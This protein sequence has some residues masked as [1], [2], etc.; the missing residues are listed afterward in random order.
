MENMSLGPMSPG[1]TNPGNTS[2]GKV[3]SGDGSRVRQ[4]PPKST[5]GSHFFGCYQ[6]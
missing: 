4:P 1:N 6:R 3:S 2:L 5:Q